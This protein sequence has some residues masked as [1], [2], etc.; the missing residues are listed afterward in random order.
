M[1]LARCAA[2]GVSWSDRIV[3]DKLARHSHVTRSVVQK[4]NLG[5]VGQVYA[6]R[7]IGLGNLDVGGR[8][9]VAV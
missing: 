2:T 7:D 1:R 4:S 9:I 6:V 3:N 8:G 5:R